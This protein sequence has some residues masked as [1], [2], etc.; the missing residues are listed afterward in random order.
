MN[1]HPIIFN[2]EMVR[3]ILDGRKTQTRRVINS[4]GNDYHLDSRLCD[5]GL[6]GSPE[7]WDGE[8]K[9]WQW[10]GKRPP[11]V[12]SWIWELQSDV[13]DS[14]TIPVKCP[15]GV[16]GDRLWVRE[17]WQNVSDMGICHPIHNIVVYR[18]TDPDWET[19]DGW[20]WRPSIY[21][22]RTASRI[23]LEVV[24]VRVERVQDISDADV[25]AEG[26]L[27]PATT[28]D[29]FGVAFST[30]WNSI[31]AKRGY[32][33]ESNCFVWVVEFKRI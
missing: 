19:M 30:L 16:P 7:Q 1:E 13:D 9:I 4:Y 25:R 15:Y 2:G 31:N 6:S 8:K 22:P 21:M 5:W 17:T 3:A 33:W 26:V 10:T 24:A 11:Q 29:G 18:A 20:K 32:S 14:M 27:F 28:I 12:N 23:M